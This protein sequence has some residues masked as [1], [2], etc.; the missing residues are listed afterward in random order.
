MQVLYDDQIS[1]L[2]HNIDILLSAPMKV[3]NQERGAAGDLRS[4][5]SQKL[6]YLMNLK[7]QNCKTYKHVHTPDKPPSPS[8]IPV[9]VS[10]NGRFSVSGR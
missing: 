7:Q 3:G 4:K 1:M 5:T 10:Y 8:F 6:I 2:F 9:I